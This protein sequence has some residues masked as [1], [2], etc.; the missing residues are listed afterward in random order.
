MQP[1]QVDRKTLDTGRKSGNSFQ[2]DSFHN[3]MARKIEIQRKQ[4][5]VVLPPP[6]LSPQNHD[7]EAVATAPADA[8]TNITE[9][10]GGKPQKKSVTFSPSTKPGSVAV[11]NKKRKS[12]TLSSMDSILKRLRRRHGKSKRR[13]RTTDEDDFEMDESCSTQLFPTDAKENA[14][15]GTSTIA[16]L[17]QKE[18]IATRHHDSPSLSS[19][20]SSEDIVSNSKQAVPFNPLRSRPDLFFYGVVIK[21]NGL[22]DPDNET[23]KRMVQKHGGDYETYETTRVTHL[24][25]E[26]LSTAKSD[27]YKKQKAPRPVCLPSWIVDSIKEGRLL[28]HASY[29]LKDTRHDPQ[30]AGISTFFGPKNAKHHQQQQSSTDPQQFGKPRK[31]QFDSYLRDEDQDVEQTAHQSSLEGKAGTYDDGESLCENYVTEESEQS[32]I[33]L[34]ECNNHAPIVACEGAMMTEF[35]VNENVKENRIAASFEGALPSTDLLLNHPKPSEQELLH[36]SPLNCP[37]PQIDSTDT[38]KLPHQNDNE[39]VPDHNCRNN[40]EEKQTLDKTHGDGSSAVGKAHPRSNK[41]TDEK[42]IDGK[43]RTV[44]TYLVCFVD[45]T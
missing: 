34:P 12:K 28:P 45:A 16:Q 21:V 38:K 23:L 10:V 3:Y 13:R 29:I 36:E 14:I 42:F 37:S 1:E 6:P 26:H 27:M 11:K 30:Q 9:A 4:F 24:I 31:L 22:T 19:S 25:A 43:L 39:K 18:A 5:G 41:K 17:E 35:D 8:S 33:H 15:Q 32:V 44:G 7:D 20:L 40:D 2:Q